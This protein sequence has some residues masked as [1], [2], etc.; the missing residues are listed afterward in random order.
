MYIIWSTGISCKLF[1]QYIEQLLWRI[2]MRIY[3]VHSY[4]QIIYD[5]YIIYYYVCIQILRTQRW[6]PEN[7]DKQGTAITFCQIESTLYVN[8][9]VIVILCNI[10]T[11]VHSQNSIYRNSDGFMTRVHSRI[12][13]CST[14]QG[15]ILRF[16]V[17]NK[18]NTIYAICVTFLSCYNNYYYY[19]F[20]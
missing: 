19:Y 2:Y 11:E 10:Y 5:V 3:N 7:C 15:S 9:R 12:I 16:I 18:I 17:F 20:L 14:K 1:D 6:F 13:V 8:L 4:T